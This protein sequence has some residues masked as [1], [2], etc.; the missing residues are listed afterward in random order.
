MFYRD[1]NTFVR[2]VKLRTRFTRTARNDVIF[3]YRE[4]DSTMHTEDPIKL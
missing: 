1:L 4:N 3:A 2:V